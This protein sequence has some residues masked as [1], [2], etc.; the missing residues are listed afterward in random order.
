VAGVWDKGVVRGGMVKWGRAGV[1]CCGGCVMWGGCDVVMWG[2]YSMGRD[3][4]MGEWRL[5]VY[6]VWRVCGGGGYE[7][8]IGV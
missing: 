3:A 4:A 5:C 1:S 2:K 6:R 7:G 8:G